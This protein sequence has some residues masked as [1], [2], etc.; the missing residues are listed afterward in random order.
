VIQSPKQFIDAI[1]RKTLADRTMYCEHIS[2]EGLQV[3]PLAIQ[4]P[5]IIR[6]GSQKELESKL[7]KATPSVSKVSKVEA[8]R[9]LNNT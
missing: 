9:P 5:R 8:L 6:E 7:I 1:S 3:K 2:F 4:T